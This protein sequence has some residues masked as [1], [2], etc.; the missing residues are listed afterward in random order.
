MYEWVR[1]STIFI[2]DLSSS[3][4]DHCRSPC[5]NGTCVCPARYAGAFCGFGKSSISN[6]EHICSQSFGVDN[7]CFYSICRNGGTCTTRFNST[8]VSFVCNCLSIFTGQFCEIQLVVTAATICS[9]ACQNGGSCILGV[10]QCTSQ[11]VGS[12]CEF[13]KLLHK[14]KRKWFHDFIDGLSFS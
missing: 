7:P 10:C 11:Y 8:S 4:F 13:G 12:A 1:I 3:W 2:L 9:P 6:I 14:K 5:V